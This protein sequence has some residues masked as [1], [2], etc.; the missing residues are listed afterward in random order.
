MLIEM[1]PLFMTAIA[2]WREARG[3][4]IEGKKAVAAVIRNR[5]RLRNEA[6]DAI[7]LQPYQFSSFNANDPEAHLLLRGCRG[8]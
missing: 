8:Q 3:E 7:V 5:A 4:P 1:Y 6:L 2:V